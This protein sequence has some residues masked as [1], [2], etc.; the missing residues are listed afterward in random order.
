MSI[1]FREL[2]IDAAEKDKLSIIKDDNEERA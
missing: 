2:Q 1:I